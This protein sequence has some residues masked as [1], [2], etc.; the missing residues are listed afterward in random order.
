MN[1]LE[2]PPLFLAANAELWRA[3]SRLQA[4]GLVEEIRGDGWRV[5]SEWETNGAEVW[6]LALAIE[7]RDPSRSS[8][9]VA[10]RRAA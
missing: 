5:W 1:A 2:Q 8:Q 3:W 4:S 10:T 7:F 6:T 9:R